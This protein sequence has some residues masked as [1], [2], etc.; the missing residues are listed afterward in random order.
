MLMNLLKGVKNN[1]ALDLTTDLSPLCLI[2]LLPVSSR[3]LRCGNEILV[4]GSRPLAGGEP[5]SKVCWESSRWSARFDAIKIFHGHVGVPRGS[6]AHVITVGE[7]GRE[8]VGRSSGGE[9]S[10]ISR[11]F[12]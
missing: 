12:S 10:D 8:K 11:S 4:S 7:G 5:R 9:N 1:S 6:N 2:E 3:A